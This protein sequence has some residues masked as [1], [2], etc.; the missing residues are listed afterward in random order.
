[1]LP[2]RSLLGRLPIKMRSVVRKH[3]VPP[4][5]L[6]WVRNM[7]Y[8]GDELFAYVVYFPTTGAF[9][10]NT[11]SFATSGREVASWEDAVTMVEALFALRD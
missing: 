11:R 9:H 1:M 2:R 5:Q 4:P 7:A 8:F 6:M 3:P 10:I